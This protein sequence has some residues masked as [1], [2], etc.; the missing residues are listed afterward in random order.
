MADLARM[1][2][3]LLGRVERVTA[4]CRSHRDTLGQYAYLY[5]EDRREVLGQFLLRGHVP[6]PEEV[7]AHAGEGIPEHP[8]R[9]QQFKAQIDSYEQLYEDVCRL[10]PARVFDGW[11]RID[12]RPFKAS[13]L[14]I[15]KKWSLMF[16]QHLVDHVTNR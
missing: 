7:E 2:S 12:L 11:M 3:T 16:K 14:N 13:L 5:A 6:A 1:R 4:L 15:I 9:L 10:E 8:P